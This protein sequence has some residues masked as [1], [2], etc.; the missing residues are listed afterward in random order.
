MFVLV[1]VLYSNDIKYKEATNN[2]AEYVVGCLYPTG[3][4]HIFLRTVLKISRTKTKD[5]MLVS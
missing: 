2:K 5:L 3:L 4:K 1:F